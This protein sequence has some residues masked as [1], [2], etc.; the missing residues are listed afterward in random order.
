MCGRFTLR[1]PLAR[2]AEIFE[3]GPVP[4]WARLQPPR[5]NVAPSQAVAAV[6]WNAEKA[7]PE[8]VPLD[9]GLVPHWADDPAI[10]NKMINAR[11]ET[12]ATKPAF[13]DALRRRRCLVLADGF[14]EWQRQ[15]S[16]KQPYYIRLKDQAPFAF[17]G[18]WDRWDKLGT[19]IESCTIITTTAND[20]LRPLHERM[21]VILN[22]QQCA[23]WLAEG[24]LET[25]ALQALL[26]PFPAEYMTAYP[27]GTVVNS[28][29]H[30]VPQCIEP[31]AKGKVQQSLFD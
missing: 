6:R 20:V 26:Q 9:W 17:A 25:P 27:V 22:R 21:P 5:Y 31:A 11:S 28:P 12:V 2:V 3:L 24:A 10:G 16:A 19:L 13:R 8:L 30:D 14:Y 29:R 18:L 4:E 15:G 23:A 7:R 1:T